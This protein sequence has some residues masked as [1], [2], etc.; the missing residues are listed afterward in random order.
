MKF[1][2][3]FVLMMVAGQFV[4]AIPSWTPT[5]EQQAALDAAEAHRVRIEY[6][7]RPEIIAQVLE[8]LNYWYLRFESFPSVP[9]YSNGKIKCKV[10][11]L[12]NKELTQIVILETE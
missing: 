5:P 8:E 6:E 12:C 10:N 1:G 7:T 3:I 4:Y 9:S 2:I 11:S